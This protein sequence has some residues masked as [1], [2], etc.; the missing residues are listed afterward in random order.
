MVT[1]RCND[2][3]YCLQQVYGLNRLRFMKEYEREFILKHAD[4]VSFCEIYH[5]C[6]FVVGIVEDKN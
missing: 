4:D 6:F 2:W 1:W 5:L 3:K